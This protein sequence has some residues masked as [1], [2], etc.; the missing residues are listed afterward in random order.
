M[1]QVRCLEVSIPGPGILIHTIEPFLTLEATRAY[2]C[3][4]AMD[5]AQEVGFNILGSSCKI[6]ESALTSTH[7]NCQ[8]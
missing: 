3:L 6:C 5:V 2:L 7:P 1:I 4:A 8:A